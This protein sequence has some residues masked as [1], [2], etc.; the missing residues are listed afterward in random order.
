MLLLSFV[1]RPP[2]DIVGFMFR[3][4]FYLPFFVNTERNATESATCS[5]VSAI[6]K[7]VS[8]IWR[9]LS[10][11][12]KI[13][14]PKNDQFSTLFGDFATDRQLQWRMSSEETRHRQMGT[15]LETTDGPQSQNFTNF[16]PQRQKQYRHFY[17]TS[18]NSAF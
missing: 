11:P 5:E 4:I 15:A 14:G 13:G 7:C 1:D 2:P 9:S 6:W 16:G 8:K 3:Y 18:V 17:P 12:L 10:F